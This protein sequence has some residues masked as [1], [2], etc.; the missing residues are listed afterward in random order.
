MGAP[1]SGKGTQASIFYEELGLAHIS[2]GDIFRG[3]AKGD[4]ELSRE[5]ARKM[6]DGEFISEELVNSTV[7]AFL[8]DKQYDKGYVLDGYPRTVE[9]LEYFVANISSDFLTVFFDIEDELI[10]KRITGRF[11]CARCQKG[12]NRFFAPLKVEGVC[13]DCGSVKFTFREDD[14]EAV[15]KK[16][17]ADF[18]NKT[19]LVIK[20]LKE[21]GDFYRIDASQPLENVMFEV[22]RLAKSI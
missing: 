10:I 5:L 8:S 3:M 12:Y 21:L 20:Q 9:Q 1:G 17:L 7:N 19:M 2:T 4:D 6:R 18:H 14:N 13:D 15:V 11:S 16:R 22:R